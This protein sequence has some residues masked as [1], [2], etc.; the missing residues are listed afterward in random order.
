[1]NRLNRWTAAALA[2]A[3]A[4]SLSIASAAALTPAEPFADFRIDAASMEVPDRTLGID[5]YRPDENGDFLHSESG[6]YDCKVN[7][8]TSD[9]ALYIQPKAE[10]VWVTVDYLTDV[11]G[12]GLYELLDGGDEPAWDS[13]T[14]Q[15]K[16]AQGGN[17]ALT[18]GQT[19]ILS[20]E[21]LA[22]RFDEAEKARAQLLGAE[23]PVTS[24]PLC[25]ITLSRT[26]PADGRTYEQLYY[27]EVFKDFILPSD[28]LRSSPYCDA[29]KYCLIQGWFSGMEDGSF[30]PDEPLNRAQLAQVLW[31]VGGCPEAEG[32][33]FTDAAPGSWFYQAVSWC[34]RE[35]LIAG[36]ED[37]SFLPEASLTREQLASIL[38]RYAGQT[39]TNPF[40]VTDLSRYEDRGDISPWAYDS[41]CWAVAN[42]LLV[43]AGSELRPGGA[44]TRAELAQALYAYR[45]SLN[46]IR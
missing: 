9:A 34:R 6:N 22:A 27:L 28:V 26:D 19:Y 45:T 24:W 42:R 14:A 7:R 21:A 39:G 46:S 3:L 4:L 43:P 1:M 2:C 33:E 15:G 41:M 31:T 32:A 38:A 20:A 18:G 35:G 11:N 25:Q 37:G 17:E 10:G 36:Y 23:A 44:V 13:L 16:L 8:I 5:T 12:D 40:S 29:I 30:G